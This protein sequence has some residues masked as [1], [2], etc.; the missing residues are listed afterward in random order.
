M[1]I[2]FL[3]YCLLCLPD[4]CLSSI[5]TAVASVDQGDFTYDAQHKSGLVAFAPA[6][7]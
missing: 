5:D 4:V 6:A 7:T 3:C 1:H 2:V